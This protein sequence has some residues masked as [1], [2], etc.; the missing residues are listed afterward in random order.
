MYKIIEIMY[1]IIEFPDKSISILVNNIVSVKII[2]NNIEIRTS[3]G[4][5]ISFR[6]AG[7]VNK[8]YND[9]KTF[10]LN[11]EENLMQIK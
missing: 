9:I 11:T 3:D 6:V 10:I 2:A 4:Y 7:D 8:L 5:P 1:K